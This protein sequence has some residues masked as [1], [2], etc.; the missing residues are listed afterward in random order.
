MAIQNQRGDS[1][2]MYKISEK[3]PC[4]ILKRPN[5]PNAR[6]KHFAEYAT[7]ELARQAVLQIEKGGKE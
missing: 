2:F 7:P 6:W 4:K 3:N 5:R 1:G